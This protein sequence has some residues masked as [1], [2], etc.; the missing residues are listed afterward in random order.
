LVPKVLPVE[1]VSQVLLV[2][3]VVGVQDPRA[4]RVL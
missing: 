1:M 4:I 2:A 3:A